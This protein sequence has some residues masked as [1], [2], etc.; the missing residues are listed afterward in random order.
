MPTGVTNG[1][2]ARTIGATCSGV[3]KRGVF[4]T[5]MN[6]RASA[7]ASTAVNASSA[8]VMP[9]ILTLVI[10]AWGGARR[11]PPGPPPPPGARPNP[12]PPRPPRP[13]CARP[14][15]PP[16]GRPAGP[17]PRAAADARAP[18]AG[19]MSPPARD[20]R[21]QLA[22]LLGPP[23]RGAGSSAHLRLAQRELS[24]LRGD[25]A[26]S[27]ECFSD[28]HG[29]SAG[30]DDPAYVGACEEAAFADDDGTGRDRR[31]ELQRCL[32][33]RLEGGEIAVVDPED[34]ASGGKGLIELGGR[35]TLD[36]RGEAESL[37]GGEQIT[38]PRRLENCHDQQ[39][40]VSARGARLPELILVDGEVLSEQRNVDRRA[41]SPQV[42]EAPLE[43]LLIGEDRDRA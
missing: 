2:R 40:G 14:T 8:L 29:V 24:D 41:H 34:A 20:A 18:P 39:H 11:P 1:G 23:A 32:Q 7:P 35:V 12:P 13:P 5:K 30:R 17:R 19:P 31:Q 37:R 36:Q 10:S 21:A 16:P 4:S 42:V 6:P 9:Q 25:V 26:G 43:I 22:A 28:Q 15:P 3:T 33:A 38:Q 27:D